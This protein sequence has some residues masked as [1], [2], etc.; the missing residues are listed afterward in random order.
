MFCQ[1]LTV[2]RTV[3]CKGLIVLRT[4][5]YQGST[6][7]QTSNCRGILATAVISTLGIFFVGKSK[8]LCLLSTKK[9]LFLQ[10]VLVFG[11]LT[12]KSNDLCLFPTKCFV[13]I[14]SYESIDLGLFETKK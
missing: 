11:I 1:E 8:D 3:F 4:V 10:K 6:V 5:N 12:Q 9:Y 14:S 7:F 13:F 2:L